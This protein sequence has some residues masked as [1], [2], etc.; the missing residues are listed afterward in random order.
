MTLHQLQG[1]SQARDVTCDTAWA[2]ILHVAT[3]GGGLGQLSCLQGISTTV[4]EFLPQNNPEK[5]RDNK[6]HVQT[7]T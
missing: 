2:K 3:G 7:R 6:P 5:S 1:S 4:T